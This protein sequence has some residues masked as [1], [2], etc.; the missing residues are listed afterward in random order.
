MKHGLECF[1]RLVR[2]L[3]G[4]TAVADSKTEHGHT[5]CILGVDVSV[6]EDGFACKPAAAKIPKWLAR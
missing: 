4:E 1:V 2:A 5:M 3:L 6:F